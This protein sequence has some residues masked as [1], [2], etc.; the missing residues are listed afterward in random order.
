MSFEA[1]I[2]ASCGFMITLV[3]SII[4]WGLGRFVKQLDEI[5]SKFE[6]LC[7]T[8]H[9]EDSLIWHQIGSMDK[10]VVRLETICDRRKQHDERD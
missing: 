6:K 3:V 10:R 7:D 8:M 1:V 5:V 2:I 9:R 4:G